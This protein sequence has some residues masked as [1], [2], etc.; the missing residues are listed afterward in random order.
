M[1]ILTHKAVKHPGSA[2][3]K[4]LSHLLLVLVLG[5]NPVAVLGESPEYKVHVDGLACPF[6]AYGIEKHLG[7][8]DG[9]HHVETH[10]NEGVVL[11]TVEDD[12]TLDETAVAGAV[13]KAGFTLNRLER[14]EGA[15]ER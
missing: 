3:P 14:V 15:G 5:L 8:I 2:A 13:K 6:C 4:W 10:I 9:V 12:V 7:R 11:V 1:A